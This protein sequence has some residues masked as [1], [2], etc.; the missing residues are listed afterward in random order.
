LDYFSG[1]SGILGLPKRD[2][3]ENGIVSASMLVDRARGTF[4]GILSSAIRYAFMSES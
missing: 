2:R 1:S 4:T 3:V